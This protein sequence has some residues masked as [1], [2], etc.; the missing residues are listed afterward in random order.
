[1]LSFAFCFLLSDD[2]DPKRDAAAALLLDILTVTKAP[3]QENAM[4]VRSPEALAKKGIPAR[5]SKRLK[6]AVA[7]GTSLEAHRP[8]ASSDDVSIA[9]SSRFFDCLNLSSQAFVWHTLMQKFLSL[10]TECIEF[11][12]TARA[13]QGMPILCYV[14]YLFSCF[15]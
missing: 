9:S 2:D 13:S 11:L 3:S 12:R 6:K 4:V 15:P 1:M 7:V 10:G 8:M 5:A 14:F